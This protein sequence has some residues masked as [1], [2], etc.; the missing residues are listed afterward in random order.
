MRRCLQTPEI[1]ELTK[2]FY[3]LDDWVRQFLIVGEEEALL[4]DTGV[5]EN[6]VAEAVRQITS[7]PVRVVLTHGDHDH[8][9]GLGAFGS[10]LV[11]PED[12]DMLPP[13]IQFFFFFLAVGSRSGRGDT[14]ECGGYRFEVL[15]IPG[16]APGS[17]AL[18]DREH[19]L[20]LPGD[21]IQKEGT[22]YMF[23]PRRNLERY[24]ES[25][26]EAGQ[27]LE[28]EI[29]GFCQVTGSVPLSRSISAGRRRTPS[30]CG[31][32]KLSGEP[33]PTLPCRICMGKWTGFLAAE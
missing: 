9:G 19:G 29:R 32:E 18:L 33:H 27:P 21:S 26:R 24:L 8:A 7:L 1:R 2:Q 14:L 6:H 20:L 11:H 23:G 10:C 30:L 3:I 22:I 17:I 12:A 13:E 31:T 4:I 16:H 5:E 28:G 25:L 15:H